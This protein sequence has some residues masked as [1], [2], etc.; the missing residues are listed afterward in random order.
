MKFINPG[1][2]IKETRKY[3]KMKQQD[4]QDDEIS[5]G[6][7]SMIEIGQRSL[8]KDVATKIVQK[9][10]TR[11][12]NLGIK[13]ELDVEY[14]LRTQK[15][16]AELYSI[17][18]LQQAS[19]PND[20]QNIL[21]IAHKFDLL[22]VNALAYNKLGDT[23]F[24]SKDYHNSF[25]NYNNSLNIYRDINQN[26]NI[27][28]LYWKAGLCKALMLNC[29]EAIIYFN[30][31]NQYASLY[32]DLTVQKSSLYDLAKCYKKLNDIDLALKH[33][34]MYLSLCDRIEDFNYYIYANILK[35]NCYEL[36]G[37]IDCVIDI[38]NAL[39]NELSD[40]RSH[41]LGYIYNNLGLAYLYTENFDESKK[42][43]EM[44]EKI[45]IDLDKSIL[46]Q[47]LIEKS[48]LFIKQGLYDDAIKSINLGLTNAKKYKNFNE[49]LKGN[50]MLVHIYEI[51]NDSRNLK[52]TYLTISKLLKEINNIPELIYIYNKLSVIYLDENNISKS[53]EYL[54]ISIKLSRNSF[55]N[56]L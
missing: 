54:L 52:N 9:F 10:C 22:N 33:I 30:F 6:L 17:K 28:K 11:A 32:K 12:E 4:L 53:R 27:A 42:Y 36:K 29:T 26:T 43:F 41:L 55:K 39:L 49:L 37:K 44:A 24:D 14:F 18:K 1:E 3:L 46:S 56:S 31:A 2:K 47:T 23:L 34:D 21:D 13:L 7:I 51:L 48:N 25:V 8:N 16:D 50:Y 5:R 38:Y 19:S 20:I 15:E 45:R 40:N 35:A